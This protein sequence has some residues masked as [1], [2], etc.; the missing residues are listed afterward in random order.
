MTIYFN[1]SQILEFLPPKNC[2]WNNSM[3]GISKRYV[4][5]NVSVLEYYLVKLLQNDRPVYDDWGRFA[6]YS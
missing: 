1:N 2:N 3:F 6:I 4:A 5:Y